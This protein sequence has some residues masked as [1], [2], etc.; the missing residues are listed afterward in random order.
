VSSTIYIRF[1]TAGR[2]LRTS[3]LHDTKDSNGRKRRR[4]AQLSDMLGQAGAFVP[5][6]STLGNKNE[7]NQNTVLH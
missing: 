4:F 5:I 6:H 7:T 3:L 1:G 2:I